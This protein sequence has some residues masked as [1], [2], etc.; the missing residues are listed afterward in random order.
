MLK[1]TTD[2]RFRQVYLHTGANAL[3]ANSGSRVGNDYPG[4]WHSQHGQDFVIGSLFSDSPPGFFVDLAANEAIYLSNTRSLERDLKWRGLCI[5]G[6]EAMLPD[7][8]RRRKCTVIGCLVS[9][10]ARSVAFQRAEDLLR[11]RVEVGNARTN[12]SCAERRGVCATAIPLA[13][14][15][16][17][18]GA[19]RVVDYLSLDVE[20]HEEAVLAHFPF[21]RYTFRAL[22]IERPSKGLQR[23]LVDAGYVRGLSAPIGGRSGDQLWLHRTVPG[24]VDAASRR[25]SIGIQALSTPPTVEIPASEIPASESSRWRRYIGGSSTGRLL[26]TTLPSMAVA[27]SAAIGVGLLLLS[28]CLQRVL[29]ALPWA[30]GDGRALGRSRLASGA[31][32]VRREVGVSARGER[33][34]RT[35][36]RAMSTTA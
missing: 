19:P 34:R 5:E 31:A 22:T 20:G 4:W 3:A 23:V 10:E 18:F 27:A 11:T 14:L 28:A 12:Q 21:D 17:A 32:R 8:A 1:D 7:L 29:A 26:P 2:A 9:N 25:A 24:G 6:N 36:R 33:E 35:E 30:V 16:D 13:A 15:L